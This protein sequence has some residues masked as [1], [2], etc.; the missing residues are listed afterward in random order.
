[1][2]LSLTLSSASFLPISRLLG[3]CAPLIQ[4]STMTSSHNC[5]EYTHRYTHEHTHSYWR[6]LVASL[7]WRRPRLSDKDKEQEEWRRRESDTNDRGRDEGGG[8]N[9]FLCCIPYLLALF[10]FTIPSLKCSRPCL[11]N[12]SPPWWIESDLSHSHGHLIIANYRVF[13]CVHVVIGPRL[14]C[15]MDEFSFI[16]DAHVNVSL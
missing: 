2:P 4:R 3:N 16:D 6:F 1:M 12:I 15:I 14:W 10:S 13:P 5:H 7:E 8:E 11:D 9:G